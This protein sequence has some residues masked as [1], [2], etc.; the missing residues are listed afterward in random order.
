MQAGSSAGALRR[1]FARSSF[2]FPCSMQ[3]GLHCLLVRLTAT[4]G[5]FAVGT[6]HCKFSERENKHCSPSAPAF[7]HLHS[8][9]LLVSCFTHA[10]YADPQVRLSHAEHCIPISCCPANLQMSQILGS[11]HPDFHGPA[12]TPSPRSLISVAS[13]H[14]SLQSTVL[15]AEDTPPL[16]PQPSQEDT[17]T[18]ADTPFLEWNI[19][20]THTELTLDVSA[21]ASLSL[22]LAQ[23]PT[24]E[25]LAHFFLQ[26]GKASFHDI[27][28]LLDLLP[29]K[30][31]A[32]RRGPLC[33]DGDKRKCFSTGAFTFSHSTGVQNNVTFFPRVTAA[34]AGIMRGMCP[35][36]DFASLML[37]R[38]IQ[39][40][41]H[42]D[43]G[44]E[45]GLLNTIVPCSRWVGGCLWLK[46]TAGAHALDQDSGPGTMLRIQLPYVQF[47]PHTPHAT[48]PWTAGDRTILIGYTPRH[49]SRLSHADRELLQSR[50]FQLK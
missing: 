15:Y 29:E 9:H 12:E 1:Y 40:Q 46:N 24:A 4:P 27:S 42:R 11:A 28:R 31:S 34:L 48:T 13:D 37:Q 26:T 3:L 22:P 19:P 20:A 38:N 43:I 7:L 50:G 44:N 10:R 47:A 45:P 33:L 41:C 32:K 21:L 16:M 39:L 23:D 8:A 35:E 17:A 36:A 14:S 5:G 30:T 2:P 6:L 25:H 49:L 18:S